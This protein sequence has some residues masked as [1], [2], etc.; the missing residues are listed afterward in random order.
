MTTPA[1]YAA[2]Y[3][4]TRAFVVVLTIDG[5][6]AYVCDPGKSWD[7]SWHTRYLTQAKIWKRMGNALRWIKDRPDVE[8][9]M[10]AEAMSMYAV[11]AMLTRMQA[12]K[13]DDR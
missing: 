4:S 2:A 9:A 13:E 10:K 8:R 3:E 5:R 7:A 1:E 11:G 12:K 6:P